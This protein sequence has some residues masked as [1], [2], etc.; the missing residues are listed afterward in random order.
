M[1][2][3]IVVGGGSAGC[4][5]A[6]RLSEDPSVTV[7]LLEAGPRDT[8][9]YIH[10]PVGFFK[11]TAGP[12]IWGYE[13]EPGSELAGRRMVYPQARVL[14]GGSSINAQ[15]F[16][17]GC[18]EDYD[19]WRDAEGCP[20]W[21]YDDVSAYFRKSEGNDTF[22]GE[23]HGNDGPL[24]VSSTSPH[25]LTRVFVRAAQQAGLPYNADFNGGHQAGAGFYQTT[26]RAG[27]RSST[28]VGYLRPAAG[29]PNLTVRTGVLVNRIVV[30]S[31]RAIGVEIVEDGR[32][33][34]LRADREVVL[35]SGAIGSPKLLMLSGIGPAEPLRRLGID[36]VHDV[37]E[38]GQNLQDH[39]DVDVLAELSGSFGIDRYKKRRWQAMAGLEYLLFGKGPVA[40]NIVEAGGFWWGDR[41]EATPDLQFHF[42]PGAGL[43]EGIGGVPG[44]HGCTLNSYHVRPRSRGAVTLRSVDPRMAPAIDPNAFAEPYDLERTVEGIQ[45]SQEVL[46][47]PAFRPFIRRLHLPGDSVRTKSDY[48]AFAREH[49]R[50]AYHPVGTCRMGGDA[51]SVVDPE[52]RLRGIEGL[53][54]CDSSVMPRLISSNTNAATI[55]IAEKAADLIKGTVP[56]AA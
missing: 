16:T 49:A 6:A 29:R 22:G 21:G 31:G 54:V 53:R 41:S 30:V 46:S 33:V 17:R 36:M 28:A 18:P 11:M 24:G 43:E 32:P 35:T 37:P 5:L 14:G 23:H 48:V 13:T 19:A 45:L 9:F 4:V 52:L 38:V 50:S 56:A 3:Y 2:D 55:M 26:T 51:D 15:V 20:G 25:P 7:T 10:L 42:L 1:P 39:M 47:Q 27:R 40:S 12:L 44:G 8:N 34:T